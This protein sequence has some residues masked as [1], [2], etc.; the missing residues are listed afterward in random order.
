MKYGIKVATLCDR[1]VNTAVINTINCQVSVQLHQKLG[2]MVRFT[3]VYR[4]YTRV[5]CII[6]ITR[7]TVIYFET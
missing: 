2:G 4:N 3:M 5:G 7:I 6:F 1:A